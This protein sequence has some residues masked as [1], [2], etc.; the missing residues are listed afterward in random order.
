MSPSQLR[1][2]ATE[3]SFW[4]WALPL[5]LVGIVVLGMVLLPAF[6]GGAWSPTPMAVIR[7]MVEI[8]RLQ[9]GETL[10]DLGAGD[11]RVLLYAARHHGALAVGIEIDPLKC[12]LI[13]LRARIAGVP[14]KVRV[15]CA[16]FFV[17]DLS[18]ADVVFSYLSPVSMERLREKF[19]Q[20][21]RP[22]ARVVSYRRS[23]P[24][25]RPDIV[26]DGIYVYT[27]PSTSAQE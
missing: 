1:G 9:A 19:V 2:D 14:D 27:V 12:W 17:T 18:G 7:R 4:Y 5:L 22:G 23:I 21:L 20:E 6:V 8:S 24:G 16:N 10:Y 11:G 3:M 26:E 25:W 13:R 15:E